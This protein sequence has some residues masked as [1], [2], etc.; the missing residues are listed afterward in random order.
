MDSADEATSFGSSSFFG[1]SLNFS[2]ANVLM[3]A[4]RFHRSRSGSTAHDGIEVPAMPSVMVRNRSWS[5]GTL[6]A[7]VRIL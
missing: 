7:V 6:F 2:A 5:D 4:T 1:A 3:Y